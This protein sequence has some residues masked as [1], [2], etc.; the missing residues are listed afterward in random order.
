[1]KKLIAVC[2]VMLLPGLAQSEDRQ[3]AEVF[4]THIHKLQDLA[5]NNKQ[6]LAVLQAYADAAATGQ[7]ITKQVRQNDLG[8]VLRQKYLEVLRAQMQRVA[9]NIYISHNEGIRSEGKYL[10]KDL[11]LFLIKLSIMP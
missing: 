10:K 4:A 5:R 3:Y 8:Q 6:D 1:M 2:V 7:E 11:Q 9:E